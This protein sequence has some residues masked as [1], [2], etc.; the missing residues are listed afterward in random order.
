MNCN[1]PKCKREIKNYY[2]CNKC[3]WNFCTNSCMTDHTLEAHSGSIASRPG[4]IRSS[5]VRS[6]FMKMGQFLKE[7]PEDPYY[8]YKNFELV[9]SNKKP[10]NIGSGAFGD[11]YLAKHKKDGKLFAIKQMDKAKIIETGATLD[12]IYREI[13]IHRRIIHENIV[14]LYSHFEDDENFYLVMDYVNA[15]TLFNVIKKTKGIDERK[16][17]NYFIQAAAAVYFLHENNLVHRD[18]KPENLLV[19][20]EE[21]VKLCDFGWCV[22]MTS[23]NRVTFCGTYEYMA[24]E[25][26]KEKPYDNSIDVWSLG[27]LLYELI[28]GYSPFRAQSEENEEYAEIFKNIIKYNFKIE[29][30]ISKGCKDLISKLLT[31]DHKARIKMREI[32]VHPWVVEFEKEAK[33]K[34]IKEMERFEQEEAMKK[35]QMEEKNRVKNSPAIGYKENKM[36]DQIIQESLNTNEEFLKEKK[37]NKLTEKLQMFEKKATLKKEKEKEKSKENSA[38]PSPIV[39]KKKNSTDIKDS[40]FSLLNSVENSSK[41]EKEYRVK[42][43]TLSNADKMN[44]SNTNYQSNSKFSQQLDNSLNQIPRHKSEQVDKD[45]SNFNSLNLSN[46]ENKNSMNRFQQTGVSNF[47]N[48]NYFSNSQQQFKGEEFSILSNKQDNLFDSVLDLVSKK[49]GKKKGGKGQYD[50]SID[51]SYDKLENS[52]LNKSKGANNPKSKNSF[53]ETNEKIYQSNTPFF[54]DLNNLDLNKFTEISMNKGDAE[55][56]NRQNK[57]T[58]LAVDDILDENY[59][60]ERKYEKSFSKKPKNDLLE[61]EIPVA[62]YRNQLDDDLRMPQKGPNKKRNELSM[63]LGENK[64]KIKDE[65]IRDLNKE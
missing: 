39:E 45:I 49:N 60:K 44:S 3:G 20:D 64:R 27:I 26:I 55:V 56:K 4:A 15:G 5:G 37:E 19:D 62:E 54:D 61:K 10:Q 13:S 32:F 57:K 8:D 34:K 53:A 40:G 47:D 29:K 38:K 50:Y 63:N 52:K 51:V 42:S 22:D 65:R 33:M 21:K 48:S 1:N 11:V 7:I 31:P 58:K 41:K 35:E 16:A 6:T 14:T 59:T 18:L 28:H 43:N 12:I 2:T 25:I 23:G 46:I 9:K 36:A 17:F 24:P 30:D